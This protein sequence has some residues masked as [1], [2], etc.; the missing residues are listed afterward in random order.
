MNEGERELPPGWAWATLQDIVE[1][2]SP[3]MY[4]ILQPGPEVENGVPYVR[5]TEIVNGEIQ[6]GAVRR[7]SQAIAEQYKRSS[8]KPSDVLLS[9]VGTVGKVATVPPSLAGANITQSSVRIRADATIILP[10]LIASQLQC[11]ALLRQFS[12][13]M[14]GTGVPRLNVGDVRTLLVVVPPLGEQ[15]RIVAKLDEFLTASRRAREALDAVPAML[16]QYRKSVLAAAFRG[17]LTED[18]RAKHPKVQPAVSL[19]EQ[20]Q[21]ERVE[22]AA[23]GEGRPIRTLSATHAVALWDVPSTWSWASL[24]SLGDVHLGQQR[25]P[26][27]QTGKYTRPYLRVANIKDDRIDYS[28]VASMDFGPDDFDHYRLRAGD[29]LLSEG[30]SP[31]LVG[32]SAIYDG[33]IDG[34]CFQKTLHRFR[35]HGSSP[36]PEFFQLVFRH[37]VKSGVFQQIASLTVNIAHLTLVRLKPLAVPVPPTAEQQ[38]I[39]RRVEAALARIEK[40][41]AYV[42]EQREKLDA[43]DRSILDKAFRGELV[44][45]APSDEPASVMLERLRA[46]RAAL[47]DGKKPRGRGRRR[48]A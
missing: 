40:V 24:E 46:E 42:A 43:L 10:S 13:K 36:S 26:Q 7:T 35:R 2:D 32:Q 14:L 37:Y 38:E 17:E 30:Q 22:R 9:I 12:D 34:L 19:L 5:P 23:L 25:A 47:G 29:I 48:E 16:D 44:P 8:L 31:Q 4:G 6:L 11:S 41:R 15:R 21:A 18:W 20:I 39:V 27:F 45:Q 33:R 1:S 28:D 3:I